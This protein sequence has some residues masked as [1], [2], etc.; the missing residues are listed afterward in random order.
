MENILAWVWGYKL[1]EKGIHTKGWP[2]QKPEP[3]YGVNN[4][5]NMKG[6]SVRVKEW[7]GD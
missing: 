2:S 3:K 6:V 1:G 5:H 7:S 4:P